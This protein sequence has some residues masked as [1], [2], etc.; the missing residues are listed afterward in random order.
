MK[1]GV[2]PDTQKIAALL[3]MSAPRDKQELKS[4]VGCVTYLAKF[5]PNLPKHTHDMRKLL[6]KEMLYKWTASHQQ[7]FEKLKSMIEQSPTLKYFDPSQEI[8]VETD[9][10]EKELVCVLMQSGESGNESKMFPAHF[11]SRSLSTAE[12]G[13]SNIEHE[14]VGMV[15]AIKHLHHYVYGQQF[16][17]ITDHKPLQINSQIISLTVETLPSNT[18]TQLQYF[19]QTW[20]ANVYQQLLIQ[21]NQHRKKTEKPLVRDSHIL[22]CEVISFKARNCH[23]FQQKTVTELSKLK[24][25]VQHGWPEN[26]YQHDPAC[27]EYW[28]GRNEQGLV[29]G[30]IFR[31]GSVISSTMTAYIKVL[32]RQS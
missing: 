3:C 20:K 12:D 9:E 8:Y 10:S 4:L 21:T 24:E 13:C 31:Q 11:A 27:K 26:K 14:T 6:G 29:N 1:E 23:E 7:Q 17:V 32:P 2:Q 18:E 28:D 25:Y 16:T 19:V 22:L 5:M 15:F 30:I